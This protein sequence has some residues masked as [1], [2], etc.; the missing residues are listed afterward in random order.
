M[1]EPATI[2]CGNA[3][4]GQVTVANMD[5]R[6]DQATIEERPVRAVEVLEKHLALAP[7]EPEVTARDAG[8][9]EPQRAS[10]IAADHGLS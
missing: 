9:V 2:F 8:I 10:D 5:R 1:D 7:N 3:E 6:I 4:N